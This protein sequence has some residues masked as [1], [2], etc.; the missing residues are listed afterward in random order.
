MAPVVLDR[1]SPRRSLERRDANEQPARAHRS[2]DSDDDGPRVDELPKLFGVAYQTG[3]VFGFTHDGSRNVI[4]IDR[5]TGVGSLFGTFSDPT[6][7]HGI[8]FAGAGVN[9]NVPRAPF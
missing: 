7:G 8:S 6:T 4:T 1:V 9:V 5:T 3:E 2:V